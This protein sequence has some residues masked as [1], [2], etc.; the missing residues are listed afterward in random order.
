L[1]AFK[2]ASGPHIEPLRDPI[3]RTCASSDHAAELYSRV[4]LKSEPDCAVFR[5]ESA[6]DDALDV[7]TSRIFRRES[8]RESVI[9]TA[10]KRCPSGDLDL[11]ESHVVQHL[12]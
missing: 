12:H 3:K 10:R 8:C 1:R 2:T 5:D 7:L 11:C 6:A 9:V 4:A